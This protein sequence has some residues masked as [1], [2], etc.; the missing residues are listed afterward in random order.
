MRKCIFF[1]VILLL[2][3]S[4]GGY[5]ATI[6]FDPSNNTISE[7]FPLYAKPNMLD[8]GNGEVSSLRTS[9][10]NADFDPVILSYN[11][12]S[13]KNPLDI[14]GV[15]LTN[16]TLALG[17]GSVNAG[18]LP[19]NDGSDSDNSQSDDSDLSPLAVIPPAIGILAFGANALANNKGSVTV[20]PIPSTMILLGVGLAGVLG[21]TRKFRKF[22]CDE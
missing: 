12:A 14:F 15:G 18:Q 6:S 21:L 7:E 9:D 5:S 10:S 1:N 17:A 16:K 11:G 22:K 3:V 4:S 13:H 19:V 2:I 8:L 20:T